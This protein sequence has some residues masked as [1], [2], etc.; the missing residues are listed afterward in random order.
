MKTI[1]TASIA[2]VAAGLLLVF[3]SCGST[4]EHDSSTA[5]Y[6]LDIM[7]NASWVYQDE[8][9]P[10]RIDFDCW[11]KDGSRR[12][13]LPKGEY[14]VEY[15]ISKDGL[16]PLK[17]R[18]SWPIAHGQK[19]S[20]LDLQ[21]KDGDKLPSGKYSLSV[22]LTLPT[23]KQVS[24]G[25]TRHFEVRNREFRL[26]LKSD[27]EE[28]ADGEK[29]VLTAS[30]QNIRG[31]AIDLK[32]L[33]AP[34]I[35]ISVGG[36]HGPSMAV[37]VHELPEQLEQSDRLGL[38]SL[39]F[40]AG[41]PDKRFSPSIGSLQIAPFGY[42]GEYTVFCRVKFR[43]SDTDVEERHEWSTKPWMSGEA[44]VSFITGSDK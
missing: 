15:R 39:T 17:L 21:T 32:T 14:K 29:I 44:Q 2:S 27:K 1:R 19:V 30:I 43:K 4:L 7:P 37:E 24:G 33:H 31:E 20:H 16:A 28:Y 9:L 8:Q 40:K 11:Q 6:V 10:V 35:M 3:C 26:F 13:Q 25:F 38:F 18:G 23:E 41:S 22:M 12:M 42:K 36:E 5:R 34:E